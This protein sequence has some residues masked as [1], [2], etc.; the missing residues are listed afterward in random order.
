MQCNVMF[1]SLKKIPFD[2]AVGTWLYFGPIIP[3]WIFDLFKQ[4]HLVG[5]RASKMGAT[6][7][8]ILN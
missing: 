8:T 5:A 2:E 1:S 6:I 3:L 7:L 4:R